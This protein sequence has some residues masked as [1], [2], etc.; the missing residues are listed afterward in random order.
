[1]KIVEFSQKLPDLKDRCQSSL[2]TGNF[3]L[4]LKYA[5]MALD[6]TQ[7]TNF[8]KTEFYPFIATS[9]YSVG[10]YDCALEWFCKALSNKKNKTECFLGLTKC[11][12]ELKKYD[13]AFFY[14]NKSIESDKTMKYTTTIQNLGIFLQ[15]D[16]IVKKVNSRKQ[17]FKEANS[18]SLERAKLCLVNGQKL[19]KVILKV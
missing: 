19:Q 18:Q 17:F 1:M 9:F 16:D 10:A 6:T 15:S 13:L 7:N 12:I 8:D 2:N 14:L 5:F 4:C 11:F 3:S